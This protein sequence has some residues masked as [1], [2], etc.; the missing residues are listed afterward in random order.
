MAAQSLDSMPVVE[1]S[2]GRSGSMCSNHDAGRHEKR[3]GW[4]PIL[5]GA[6]QAEA[7]EVVEATARD[8]AAMKRG[9]EPGRLADGHAGYALFFS[10]A[11]NFAA[12]DVAQEIARSLQLATARFAYDKRAPLGLHW[13]FAGLG[14]VAAYLAARNPGLDVEELCSTIDARL[15]SALQVRPWPHPCDIRDGLAGI[16]LYALQRFHVPAGRRLLARVVEV[17]DETAQ[18][19]PEGGTWPMPRGYWSI[20][21]EGAEFPQG[22]YSL[23]VAHGVPGALAILAAA[24]ANDVERERADRLLRGGFRWFTLQAREQQGHPYFP[25]FLKGA[26]PV[27]DD[28]FSWCVGNP[29]IVSV[30]WWAAR[31][32]GDVEWQERTSGWA[33]RVAREGLDRR[34]GINA[35]LCCGTSG[36]A[37]IFM[38]LYHA[39]GQ[40]LFQEVAI[41]WLQHTLAL[42]TP[43][44]GPGGFCFEMNPDRPSANLHFGAT[45]IALTLLAAASDVAP[46]WDQSFLFSLKSSPNAF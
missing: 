9:G 11:A 43:G 29:G 41:R 27:E 31:L 25:H 46:D 20:Y 34:P 18:V 37:L 28:R 40:P 17:L 16:G 3:K 33:L 39:T 12:Q 44:V 2:P 42:R 14:W 45:G 38:R 36:T 15:M 22:L 13:G 8:V 10:T 5:S 26:T 21:E 4:H 7:L 23:G 6:H 32:W 35:N 19:S 1:D 30:L 24:H